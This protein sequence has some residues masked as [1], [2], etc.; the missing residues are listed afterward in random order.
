MPSYNSTSVST[1]H[2]LQ[3]ANLTDVSFELK[4]LTTT[5]IHY[6]FISAMENLGNHFFFCQAVARERLLL[7]TYVYLIYFVENPPT[8]RAT[9]FAEAVMSTW[10]RNDGNV[11]IILPSTKSSLH[12]AHLRNICL[13]H[14]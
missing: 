2:N 5:L 9:L 3:D 8:S 1:S 4:P 14:L 6:L 12:Q 10:A 11:S 13:S 7:N